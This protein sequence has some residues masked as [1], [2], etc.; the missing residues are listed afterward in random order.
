MDNGQE[1]RQAIERAGLTQA[2]ALEV[3][4]AGLPRPLSLGHWK[5]FLAAPDSSRWAP[6]P[7]YVWERAQIVFQRTGGDMSVSVQ[8]KKVRDRNYQVV[9]TI[10]GIASKKKADG[11]ANYLS[12]IMASRISE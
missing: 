8:S 3:F 4:N 5:S 11:M 12:Q 9:L 10:G 2:R 7:D 1:L 6:C